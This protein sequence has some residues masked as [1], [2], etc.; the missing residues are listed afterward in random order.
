MKQRRFGRVG[1]VLILILVGVVL[2]WWVNSRTNEDPLWFMRSFRP[3]AAWIV[4][5]WEGEM[6]MLFPGDVG[7]D[8]I[9]RAFAKGLGRWEHYEK[10]VE[11][12]EEDL[13]AYRTHGCFMELHYNRGIQ[14]HTRFRY[15]EVKTFFVPLTGPHAKACRVFAGWND[16]PRTGVFTMKDSRFDALCKAIESSLAVHLTQEP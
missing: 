1:V 11:L 8:P 10:E 12:S 7:Y 15:P 9:M 3:K 4:V 16:R 6:H 14:V 2:V 5:Y 13:A